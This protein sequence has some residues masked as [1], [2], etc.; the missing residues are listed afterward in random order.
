VSNQRPSGGSGGFN[1]SIRRNTSNSG[2]SGVRSITSGLI[3]NKTGLNN[4]SQV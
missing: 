4:Q 2:S 3:K 1:N